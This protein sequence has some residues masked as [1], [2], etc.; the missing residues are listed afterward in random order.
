MI[1]LIARRASAIGL[2]LGLVSLVS[3][4]HAG[5]NVCYWLDESTSGGKCSNDDDCD[6][7][8]TCN[9]GTCE[10]QA[11]PDGMECEVLTPK[12]AIGDI[13]V[14]SSHTV[15]FAAN[16]RNAIDGDKKTRWSS[17]WEAPE[18]NPDD[19]TV[20]LELKERTAIKSVAIDWEAACGKIYDVETSDDGASWATF[21]KEGN[22]KP[23][24]VVHE[25]AATGR[26]VRI[27][28][29]KRCIGYGYS[30]WEIGVYG[31][32]AH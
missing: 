31:P 27:H 8:R 12:A 4:A 19:Q 23:G 9:G 2:A 15:A 6:G 13:K 10:G 29:T 17:A 22:G 26:F 11:R 32:P 14:T 3:A 20:T 7:L 16:P 18:K 5:G 28:G 21:A 24:K 25:G 30:I 1:D